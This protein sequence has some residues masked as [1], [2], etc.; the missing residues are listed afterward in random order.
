[1]TTHRYRSQGC[2]CHL[3]ICAIVACEWMRLDASVPTL[4]LVGEWKLDE[5]SGLAAF[6]TSGN[7]N[8]GDL[9]L[10]Q[11]VSGEVNSALAFDGNDSVVVPSTAPNIG[12]LKPSTY[13]VSAWVKY[14]ATDT[15]GGEIATMGDSYGLRVTSNGDVKTYFYN[16]TTWPNV[17]SSSFNT[18]DGR[19]H[20]VV[21][22]YTGAA[23]RVY[24]DGG[25]QG[26]AVA[27]GAIVYPTGRAF[28]IGKHGNGSGS[29]DFNGT[30]DQVRVY[31]RALSEI[32]IADLFA[33]GPPEPD[34]LKVLTWNAH[35]CRTTDNILD[36]TKIA[37]AV[38]RTGADVALLSAVLQDS[39]ALAIKNQLNVR[40][41]ASVWSY[42]FYRIG[43]EG[44]AILSKNGTTSITGS[45]HQDATT[46]ACPGGNN[47]SQAIVEGT[48]NT[49]VGV[50]SFFG[51]DQ[52]HL[53]ANVRLCQAT[54]F[55]DWADS[56]ANNFAQPRIVGG[57]FNEASGSATD[58]WRQTFF[59]AYDLAP[60]I[61]VVKYPGNSDGRTKRTRL[62]H[63]LLSQSA[64]GIS[65][66]EGRVWDMRDFSKGCNVVQY[67]VCKPGTDC[68]NA[69]DSP[70]VDDKN[71]RPSDHSP[72]TVLFRFPS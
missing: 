7:N 27:S 64:T 34:T 23:L 43:T 39:D 58:Y 5:N 36:C 13:T 4:S 68:T 62:D 70:Y 52:D 21:G 69:C 17:V 29:Y 40:E 66:I 31:S 25:F 41:N 22:M 46:S 24:I 38:Y 26:D 44:Q 60:A 67:T 33:E 61:G 10:P 50:G 16:G 57:D 30:I 14:T 12:A 56:V 48:V 19:W 28:D 37:D 3:A 42:V 20:H 59:D 18:K 49:R 65:V 8:D 2:V 1:M 9:N 63:I 51:I 71:P 47:E 54:I 11:W 72:L 32:E 15:I 55:R 6:D 35:K 53:D 45:A